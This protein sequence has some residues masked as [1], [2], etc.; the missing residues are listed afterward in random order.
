MNFKNKNNFVHHP[1]IKF[2]PLLC[3]CAQEC[4]FIVLSW[5]KEQNLLTQSNLWMIIFKLECEAICVI[6]ILIWKFHL[7]KTFSSWFMEHLM[8][9]FSVNEH[10]ICSLSQIRLYS[11]LFLFSPHADELLTLEDS[12]L[13]REVCGRAFQKILYSNFLSSLCFTLWNLGCC[14]RFCILYTGSTQVIERNA[15]VL[16]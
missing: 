7:N 12:T 3:V 16:Q 1:I 2:N 15:N 6:T 13:N 11:V 10:Q 5:K 9:P 8:L 4:I 14:V